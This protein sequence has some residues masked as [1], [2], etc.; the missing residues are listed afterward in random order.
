MP[1]DYAN[2]SPGV[3]I[4]IVSAHERH[5]L[6]ATLRS[7]PN[8]VRNFEVILVVPKSDNDAK[9]IVR[10]IGLEEI[11]IFHDSNLGI[12]PAMN[13]GLSE[14]RYTHV[15]FL[16]TGDLMIGSSELKH[17]LSVIKGKSQ[18]SYIFPVDVSWN[19]D[20][21]ACL[22]DLRSFI[23][24]EKDAYV[25]HQGVLFL[26]SF[27]TQ[28]GR[29]DERFKIAADFKQLCKLYYTQNFSILNLKLVSIEFPNVSSKFNRRGRLESIF[30]T[31]CYLRGLLRIRATS[32]RLRSEFR[33]LL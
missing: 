2:L 13:I 31:I 23:A 18:T 1:N 32:T 8:D 19:S 6:L 10:E 3:S 24:G 28:E 30:V 5:R 26:T 16:N 7:I 33:N 11:R 15:L 21:N 22:P 17:C 14:A 25:S 4:V 27:V 29:L 12:Y 9:D 20:L